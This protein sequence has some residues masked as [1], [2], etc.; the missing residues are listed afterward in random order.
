M[1]PRRVDDDQS[2]RCEEPHIAQEREELQR[3]KDTRAAYLRSLGL[4]KRERYAIW[5]KNADCGCW[6]VA[7]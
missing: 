4:G 6:T 1:M 5:T 7:A 2:Y 3:V